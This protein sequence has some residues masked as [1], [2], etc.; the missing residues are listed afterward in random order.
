MLVLSVEQL[1]CHAQP[2]R[3]I[4]VAGGESRAT[5]R[6]AQNRFFPARF[7]VPEEEEGF[8]D[9]FNHETKDFLYYRT[10]GYSELGAREPDNIDQDK[11]LDDARP[12][13]AR[14]TRH[15]LP[16]SQTSGAV[17]AKAWSLTASQRSAGR[18][19]RLY[20]T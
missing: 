7:F 1:V 14:R 11:A 3:R 16:S 20:E 5:G 9:L 15:M 8:D 12:E 2:R 13:A 19:E 4:A 6:L 10:S 18:R 17:F